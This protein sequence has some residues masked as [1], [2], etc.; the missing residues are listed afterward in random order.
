MKMRIS[1]FLIFLMFVLGSDAG[2]AATITWT[3]LNGGNW[4]LAAN[5]NPNQVP[6]ASDTAQITTSGTYT[7][8]N[9]GNAS[10]SV[11]TLG[12]ASGTQ[13]L[14]LSSGVF[15]LGSASTGNAQGVLNVSGGTLGGAGSLVLAGPLNWSGGTITNVVQFTGG[16]FSG[17]LS[18]NGGQVIN[19][20]TL[21]WTATSTTE[22]NGSIISNAVA[23]TINLTANF[24]EGNFGGTRTFINA[25]QMNVT[26]SGTATISDTFTNTG[27]VA[28][29][30]GTLD[31]SGGGVETG[32]FTVAS[33]ATLT[34]GGGTIAFNSGSSLSGAG[35]FT[36]AGGTATVGVGLNLGGSWTF[37]G[38]T[39]T[40]T[41]TTTVSGNAVVVSG[42]TVNFNGAGP[43]Q[44]GTLSISLGTLGGTT[45][46]PV[47]N[48]GGLTWSGGTITNVVQFTGGTFSGSLSLNGGQVI[49][50]G[51]LNWTATSMTEGNGSII[52]NAVAGTINLTANFS[53][54]NFGGTRVFINAGQMNVAVS[55]TANISDTFTNTGTVAI[56]AGILDLSGSHTLANGTLNFGIT[57]LSTFGVAT[58][59]GASALAGT[60]SATFNGGFLP[61]V[62]NT[63]QII[64]YTS[65]SGVFTQTNLPPVAIW[66]VTTNP[67]F[68]TIKVVKLVP[69]LSWP[70]PADIVYGTALSSTQLD[71]TATWNGSAVAGTFNYNPALATVLQSGS[72]QTLSV[73]FVPSDPSTY[74]N[75]TTN[76]TINVQKAPLS[77]TASNLSKTYG[78]NITFAGTEFVPTGLV[79]GDT[80]TS[81]TLASTGAISNAPVSGSPYAITITNALGD[82]GLTNYN[83]SYVNGT[84][85]VN[86]AGLTVTANN[87]A[88]NYGVTNPV[89]SASYSGFVNNETNSVVS[90]VPGFITPATVTSG[91]G[92]Y[93][94]TP[95][96]GSLTATNYTFGPFNPGTL[97]INPAA[98][99][100]MASNQSKT[101]GQKF[102]FAGTEF[103]T[104][105]LVNGDSVTSATL[106]STGAISNAP[107]SGSPYAI[108]IT[109]AL[110]DAGLT[111][112]NISYI[113][114]ALTVN[115]AA[116]TITA[117][118]TNK[119][120]GETLT[121]A[122][123]AFTASGLQNLET[124][125]TVTLTSA[126]TPA[127]AVAGAY[128]IVPSAPAGGTFSQ[129]NYTNNFVNGTLTVYGQP[130]LFLTTLGNQ[131]V[132]T[133]QTL[134]GQSY[135]VQT[136]TNV[137]SAGWSSL[138]GAIPGTGGIVNKTNTIVAPQS[139][140][141]LLIGPL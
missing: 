103:A 58:L 109:N 134:S 42:G 84:L 14:N 86:P 133:F 120:V 74:T 82:A 63:W 16:T 46:V 39:A 68:L 1:G 35:N 73:T 139:F 88:R 132:L 122:G 19:S 135:Q 53:E 31:L 54:G 126:G 26:V 7:V 18:L 80:V 9:S 105:G 47:Q 71:A 2:H 92:G 50:S 55:G 121:F 101:Y 67:T 66:Q 77:V 83:I 125:G 56:N 97:T 5:W 61:A 36:V 21:N 87:A 136:E 93:A 70:T 34:L 117:N 99:S 57:N 119:I 102:V 78:Q 79:N 108:T 111:N 76:V 137:V 25:G 17:S 127:L 37:S 13:T 141:R 98:L 8:T 6:G 44:P 41:S 95:L 33:G 85:T 30:G 131:Y 59:S 75:V 20:G 81:A 15:T 128:N 38:G 89:F 65:P 69:Q 12:G 27:T 29:N 114:G 51:T 116:L 28:V 64:N 118:S 100:I 130:E 113:N 48:V 22:G 90:G 72:N 138:G 60:L 129:G 52:S 45:A 124:V 106:A 123:T 112:Y 140:F 32:P 115:K 11:L 104:S 43:W 110:G 94:I 4:S 91:V 23:G 3:N 40:L 49:N 24:S 62:N 96:L 107:V 10:V